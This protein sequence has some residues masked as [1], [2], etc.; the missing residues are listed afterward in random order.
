MP[1]Y[2]YMFPP[3]FPNDS[4]NGGGYRKMLGW[5]LAI[6]FIALAIMVYIGYKAYSKNM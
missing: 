3:P 6:F 5:G 1:Y 4:L 2:G